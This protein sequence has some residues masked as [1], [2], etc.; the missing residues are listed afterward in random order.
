MASCWSWC[1]WRHGWFFLSLFR[2]WTLQVSQQP[3]TEKNY[4]HTLKGPKEDG[5][6]LVR[7]QH[8][9]GGRNWNVLLIRVAAH[10]W[11]CLGPS[12]RKNYFIYEVV[13]KKKTTKNQKRSYRENSFGCHADQSSQRRW[14]IC[15]RWLF[16]AKTSM[17]WPWRSKTKK[18]LRTV[19]QPRDGR[20]LS[21]YK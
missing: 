12:L 5:N 1:V 8:F 17:A 3:A 20:S 21:F 10:F 6:H 13:S 4:S 16:Y 15:L 19:K 2:W 7:L 9:L 18:S 11:L 14:D